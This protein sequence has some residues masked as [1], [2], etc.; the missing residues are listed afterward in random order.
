M[1]CRL[2]FLVNIA[3][4]TATFYPVQKLCAN[5]MIHIQCQV[6]FHGVVPFT[7]LNEKYKC[8]LVMK[9]VSTKTRKEI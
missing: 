9:H 2:L 6:F 4:T 5:E 3:L 7:L 1:Q 8:V